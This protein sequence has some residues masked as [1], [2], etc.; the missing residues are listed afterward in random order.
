MLYNIFV[1]GVRGA[2]VFAH[3]KPLFC[4]RPDSLDKS[5]ANAGQWLFGST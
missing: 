5:L 3:N 1:E 2:A 4:A